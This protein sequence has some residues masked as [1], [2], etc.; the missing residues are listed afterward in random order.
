VARTFSRPTA[1]PA[2]AWATR[3]VSPTRCAVSTAWGLGSLGTL[4][5]AAGGLLRDTAHLAAGRAEN[6]AHPRLHA[7][8]FRDM[9]FEGTNANTNCVFV[10][11]KRPR[12]VPVMPAPPRRCAWAAT[13]RP[14]RSRTRASRSA[15]WTR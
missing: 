7:A 9:G 8:A 11:I 1:W 15:R 12:R 6:A 13:S 14:S 3:W 10:D 4:S 5:A 2:C